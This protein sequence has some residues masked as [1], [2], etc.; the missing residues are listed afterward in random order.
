MT[1]QYVMEAGTITV[2]LSAEGFEVDRHLPG[3][4][5]GETLTFQGRS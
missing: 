5:I 3:G 1:S 4:A 2:R